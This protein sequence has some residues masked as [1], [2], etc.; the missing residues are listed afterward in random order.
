MGL[1]RRAHDPAR[2]TKDV[3]RWIEYFCGR[4]N[5]VGGIAARNQDSAVRKQSG[6]MPSAR[7]DHGAGQKSEAV[8]RRIK[9]FRGSQRITVGSK[10]SGDKNKTIPK[11]RKRKVLTTHIHASGRGECLRRRIVK[12]CCRK[13]RRKVCSATGNEDRA[14]R[15]RHCRVE[16]PRCNHAAGLA[17]A[18]NIE[19]LRRRRGAASARKQ[20]IAK[21]PAID[22]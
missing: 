5:A 1:P 6:D 9:E 12:L 11:K 15:E 22:G 17:E 4:Y 2:R 18:L 13:H 10:T 14:I 20:R 3:R 8:C 7:G 16:C 19:G 21:L